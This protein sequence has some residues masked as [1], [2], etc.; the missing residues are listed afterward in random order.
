LG[1]QGGAVDVTALR[2]YGGGAANLSA[3]L[4]SDSGAVGVKWQKGDLGR[5]AM[6]IA[7]LPSEGGAE[8]DEM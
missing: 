6:P 3:G 1:A 5:T 2:D 8:G 4:V 7:G